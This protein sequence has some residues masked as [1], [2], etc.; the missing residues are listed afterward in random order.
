MPESRRLDADYQRGHASHPMPG[1]GFEAFREQPTLLVLGTVVMLVSGFSA[2]VCGIIGLVLKSRKTRD[3]RP[4]ARWA[5]RLGAA[6][7]LLGVLGI[8]AGLV[9]TFAAFGA[10]GLSESDRQRILSNGI[11]ESFYNLVFALV[12]GGP[13]LVLG[14]FGRRA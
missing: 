14:F 13:G 4:Y 2:L 6:V 5:R 10:L 8:V 11:A 1:D 12:L 7:S 9:H 3:H